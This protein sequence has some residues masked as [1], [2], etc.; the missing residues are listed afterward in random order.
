MGVCASH[1]RRASAGTLRGA[2]AH[3]SA[4]WSHASHR[5]RGGLSGAAPPAVAGAS[6]PTATRGEMTVCQSASGSMAMR[7]ASSGRSSSDT[8]ASPAGELAEREPGRVARCAIRSV[9]LRLPLPAY[10]SRLWGLQR[11]LAA[12]TLGHLAPPGEA[13]LAD[14]PAHRNVCGADRFRSLGSK[15]AVADSRLRAVPSPS[16]CL[17]SS[18]SARCRV[19]SPAKS[20]QLAASGA[21][22]AQPEPERGDEPAAMP[23]CVMPAP[24]AR[25]NTVS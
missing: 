3:T 16:F 21:R 24:A 4:Q 11:L 22:A 18:P 14:K 15:H 9:C 1:T 13:S 23:P 17:A 7:V 19:T 6:P 10:R 8:S 25:G 12:H 5:G 2:P 20:G